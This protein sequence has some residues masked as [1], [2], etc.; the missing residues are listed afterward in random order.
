MF[1]HPKTGSQG[2]GNITDESKAYLYKKVLDCI[3]SGELYKLSLDESN[4]KINFD[5][6]VRVES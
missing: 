5:K 3:E 2:S 4:K 1:V 6:L